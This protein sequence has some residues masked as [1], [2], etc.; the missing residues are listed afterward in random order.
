[1]LRIYRGQLD[2]MDTVKHAAQGLEKAVEGR[3]TVLWHEIEEWQ[4]DNHYIHSG[5]RPASKSFLTSAKRFITFHS[6]VRLTFSTNTDV[7]TAL[8]TFTMKVSTYTRT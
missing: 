1:V 2:T 4:Q 5:Y 7:F 8:A 6:E 3:L